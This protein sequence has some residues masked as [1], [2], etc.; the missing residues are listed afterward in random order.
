MENARILKTKK[1]LSDHKK[2]ALVGLLIVI[3]CGLGLILIFAKKE[4]ETTFNADEKESSKKP[5]PTTTRP[6]TITRPPTTTRPPT[7]TNTP[8]VVVVP[9]GIYVTGYDSTNLTFKY[10]FR[11][12]GV[13][14]R[15]VYGQNDNDH[16]FGHRGFKF[17][18][19]PYK[20]DKTVIILSIVN[21]DGEHLKGGTF[22]YT[23][24]DFVLLD[25]PIWEIEISNFDAA[26]KTFDYKFNHNGFI[27]NGAF[28][29]SK[30]HQTFRTTNGSAFE[31]QYFPADNSVLLTISKAP[32]VLRRKEI[33][34]ATGKIDN[35]V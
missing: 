3:I 30:P 4:D 32:T 29:L 20:R 27:K 31:I 18:V 7:N 5:T 6:S 17:I 19:T 1:F 8:V 35:Q 11:Y 21:G 24:G 23:S 25:D 10:E 12:K 9:D 34:L 33:K 22:T 15:G 14:E 2:E 26:Y 16:I 28:R 13:L